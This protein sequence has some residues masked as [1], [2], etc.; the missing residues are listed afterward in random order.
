MLFMTYPF[1][2]NNNHRTATTDRQRYIRQLIEQVL[3]TLP[4]E[5][6]NRPDFGSNLSY[7]IFASVSDELA[8]V[9]QFLIQG[10]L[11]QWLGN[12]IQIEAV[13]LEQ[14]DQI[15][16]VV[17]QYTVSQTQQRVVERFTKPFS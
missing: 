3:F 14:D 2:I 8:A 15:L 6:V 5:R 11:Q 10:A 1:Q 4:G 17:V 16:T 12:I 9:N 7:L 13:D